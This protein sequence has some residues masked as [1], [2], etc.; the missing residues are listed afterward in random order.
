MANDHWMIRIL[1]RGPGVSQAVTDIVGMLLD[2]IG[3]SAEGVA[4]GMDGTHRLEHLF[5]AFRKAI[6]GRI[7]AGKLGVSTDFGHVAGV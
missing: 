6:K 1:C 2:A 4:A 7:H 3:A 5:Q